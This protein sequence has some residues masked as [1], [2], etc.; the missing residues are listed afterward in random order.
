MDRAVKTGERRETRA[1]DVSGDAAGEK[2]A[3]PDILALVD[4]LYDDEV[5]RLHLAGAGLLGDGGL[6]T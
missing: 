4:Q 6:G 2:Q 5:K 3:L 1:F